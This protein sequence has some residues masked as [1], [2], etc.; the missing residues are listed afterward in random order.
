MRL[1]RANVSARMR[2]LRRLEALGHRRA[3]EV[4]LTCFA[5]FTAGLLLGGLEGTV[6]GTALW[7]AAAAVML[8]IIANLGRHPL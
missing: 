8:L 3:W 4:R 1:G 6:A 5:L 7:V 2:L